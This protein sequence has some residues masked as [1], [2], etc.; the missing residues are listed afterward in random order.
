V[1]DPNQIEGREDFE[2]IATLLPQRILRT[3]EK[4]EAGNS[5]V[6]RFRVAKYA[7]LTSGICLRH[8]LDL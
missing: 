7:S 8:S 3:R 1:S 4:M 6:S 5:N 2:G